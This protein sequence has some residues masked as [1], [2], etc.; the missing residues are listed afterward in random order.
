MSMLEDRNISLQEIQE[1]ERKADIQANA[2][3]QVFQNFK[4]KAKVIG[5]QIGPTVTKF[6]I[7][8]EPGTKVNSVVSLENDLKMALTT[9]SIRLEHPI[10]G[11]NAIGIEVPNA[12]QQPVS[13]KSVLSNIPINK[14]ASKLLFGLGKTV[15]GEIIHGELNTMPHLL[16]AGSTGSGKSVM[17]NGIISSILMRAKPHEVKFLMIDPKQVELSIY[18]KIPHL[19]APVISDMNLASNALTRVI[20]EMERRYGLFTENNVKKIDEYNKIQSKPANK[21]P[22][23]II[24]IDELADLM[25]TANKKDVEDAIMRLTQ[26]ARA[27]GIH[28]IVATQRPSTDVL[29]GVIKSNIPSRIAFAVASY[30]DSRTILDSSGAEKLIGKGDL[31]YM[32]PGDNTL[33]RA[34]GAFISDEEIKRIVDFC[35]NQQNQIFEE[36]FTRVDETTNMSNSS[37]SGGSN[38]SMYE[39]IKSYVI[40]IQ[41]ASTSLIQRRFNIG[42]NRAANIIDDLEAEGVIGPQNGAKP[43]EPKNFKTTNLV[44]EIVDVQ[45]IITSNE[46]EALLLEQNLIKSHKPKYNIVLND[47]KKYPY[48][49]I[50]NEKDPEYK[51]VRNY[52]KNYKYNFGPFPD[53]SK[54]YSIIKILKRVY[55]LRNCKGN[56]GKPC[57]YYQIN[58]CS[59][60]CFKNV[61]NSYYEEMFKK[62]SNFFNADSKEIQEILILKIQKAVELL[63]FEEAE[64]IKND[65]LHIDLA[66][67]KQE[68]DL[69]I[70]INLDVINYEVIDDKI[71]FV[72]IFYRGGKMINLDYNIFDFQKEN[73]EDLFRTFMLQLYAKNSSDMPIVVPKKADI[74][75]LEEI[76]KVTYDSK[77]D[78]LLEIASVNAIEYLK[79]QKLKKNIHISNENETLL[80]LQN[81]INLDKLP[82]HIEVYDIANLYE[83]HITGGMVVFKGAKVSTNEFRKYNLS[84]GVFKMNEK[85]IILTAEGLE[86]LKI[87]LTHLINVVRPEVIEELVEARAHGDLSE[88]ADYD[89]ARNRQAEV[90]ARIKELEAVISK[91]KVIDEKSESKGDIKVGSTVT[92]KN[93]NTNQEATMKIVG[94]IEAD[95]FRN[96]ISNE[97]PLAKS[98]LG[99]LA[100]DTVEVKEVKEPYKIKISTVK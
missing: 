19:L 4:V 11:K 36:E 45:T 28:L 22:Y 12:V 99:H 50:T 88:N 94:A 59:G 48:I 34:Q 72:I 81:I 32:K 33:A 24:V 40:E 39:Q 38:D 97:S 41:K 31:L 1:I 92:F 62:I 85:E 93:L 67:K 26:M 10:P 9:S 7:Q 79:N 25:L 17:I 87:E 8:P 90:E 23:Y 60:A 13:L 43:R 66:I 21:L 55:P 82:Y 74:T 63:Q 69:E 75:E 58:Q 77:F 46:K 14:M 95:P 68:V 6:E 15:T 52:N 56:L 5:R 27:A 84:K 20:S 3:N 96:H 78:N 64:R 65:L 83:E 54:A 76:Y 53:G 49:V 18:S 30:I 61:L 71:C 51:Y 29:T 70:K 89:A 91:A 42:Y 16:V 80:E 2:I 35:A 47:D 100:G 73:E 44:N 98:M 37:K 57:L 86:E